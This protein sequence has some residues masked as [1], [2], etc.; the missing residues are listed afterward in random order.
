[1]FNPPLDGQMLFA[2]QKKLEKNK[3][4]HKIESWMT[5]TQNFNWNFFKKFEAQLKNFWY[6]KF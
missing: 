6:E 4:N 3:I 1:M 5:K 2:A